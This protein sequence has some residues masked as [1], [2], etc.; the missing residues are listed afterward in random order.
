MH[1]Q[2]LCRTSTLLLCVFTR[3]TVL[4]QIAFCF[5]ILY[6]NKTRKNLIFFFQVKLFMKTYISTTPAEFQSCNI[7]V[8]MEF[9][10]GKKKKT[11]GEKSQPW[12]IKRSTGDGSMYWWLVRHDGAH[13]SWPRNKKRSRRGTK[14]RLC[15]PIAV[16]LTQQWR[17]SSS[18]HSCRK[19]ELPRTFRHHPRKRQ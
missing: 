17:H 12:F 11:S 2:H 9:G 1:S 3:L 5:S 7:L 15:P 18:G 6:K 14:P 10:K 13:S 16:N 19:E 4:S 8:R